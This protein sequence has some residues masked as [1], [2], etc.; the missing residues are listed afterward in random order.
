[1]PFVIDRSKFEKRAS[2]SKVFALFNWSSMGYIW[3]TI[4]LKERL[5]WLRVQCCNISLIIV[6]K[7][8]NE[9]SLITTQTKIC[10]K[11][12][13]L[14]THWHIL[15]WPI[16]FRVKSWQN[17]V[18]EIMERNSS[19]LEWHWGKGHINLFLYAK[20]WSIYIFIK[21]QDGPF[22]NP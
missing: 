13:T 11:K 7:R 18:Q 4:C 3:L 22:K 16:R 19:P 6:R 1:M 21:V 12:S 10:N 20:Y 5:S 8:Q 17:I 15:N 14:S 2:V 9:V